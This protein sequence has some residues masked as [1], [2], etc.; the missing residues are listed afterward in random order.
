MLNGTTLKPTDGNGQAAFSDLSIT[1]AP[2]ERTLVFAATNVS[3][4]VSNPI[5]LTAAATST[6]ITSDSPDPSDV[7]A[8]VT[9]SFAVT[10]EGPT[11]AGEVTVGDG[12]DSC[13]GGL[14]NG[15]GSCPLALSTAGDRTLT[16]TYGGGEGLLGS[17]GTAPHRVNPPNQPPTASFTSSCTDL[18]CQ[19]TDG[20]T[21]SEG[22]IASRS[23]TFGDLG[24]SDQKDPSHNYAGTGT[25]QVTLTVTDNAG[26]MATASAPVS[27]TA[28]LPPNHPP[29]AEFSPSCV[30]LTCNFTDQSTDQDGDG[31]ITSRS[32]NYGDN[33]QPSTTPSH[34]YGSAGHYT[35]TLTVTDDR[36]GTDSRPHDVNVTAP[37]QPPTAAFSAPSCIATQ[38]CLFND[39]STDS[40]GTV[41]EWSWAFGDTGT[42]SEKNPPHTYASAGDYT[43][44]LTVTDNDGASSTVVSHDVAV[45]EPPPAGSPK[46]G[47]RTAP[48]ATTTSGSRLSRDLE[49]AL[50]DGSG[51]QLAVER[52]PVS[53]AIGSGPGSLGGSITRATDRM[54][55]AKFNDLS[56]SAASGSSVT[57]VFTAPGYESVTSQA[58]GVE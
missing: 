15:V 26:A 4:V 12:V 10:S 34:T 45:T 29:H 46:L 19:F 16:A 56:I 38:P 24:T 53:A 36:G 30:D 1:G 33:T 32:W 25:Y 35:V 41:E 22:P 37:N 54:G 20:S 44:T 8:P 43:V 5:N 14:V 48:P 21:D 27:V 9:V 49:L 2:G 39:G 18:H 23:W 6:H 3:G 40:D 42:S 50:L 13:T 28:P 55:R 7:G 17:S 57:L 47:F 31:T 52:V 51:Q 11:P 58:I